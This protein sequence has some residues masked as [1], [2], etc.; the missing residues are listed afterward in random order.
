MFPC[1]PNGYWC[2][3]LFQSFVFSAKSFS[4]LIMNRYDFQNL[5]GNG[6][7]LFKTPVTRLKLFWFWVSIGSADT[8]PSGD[9]STRLLPFHKEK[10]FTFQLR[11]FQTHSSLLTYHQF[12]RVRR[13]SPR[14]PRRVGH[15]G[16]GGGDGV[17]GTTA[18]RRLPGGQA[19]A[20]AGR[21]LH[22]PSPLLRW[23]IR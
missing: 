18:G 2:P 6:V 17:A 23:A 20:A 8:L 15:S 3:F 5:R 13:S 21:R 22:R 19:R 9:P 11:Y 4:P 16:G 7:L 10:E 14:P 12:S 1:I